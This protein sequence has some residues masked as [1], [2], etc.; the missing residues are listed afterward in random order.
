MSP[1]SRAGL[2]RLEM[3][4]VSSVLA[5][6][7]VLAVHWILTARE[8]ARQTQCRNHLRQIGL[9]LHNYHDSMST[10]PPGFISDPTDGPLT[11]WNG[12]GW[13]AS[14][15]P[16]I[17]ASPLYNQLNFSVPIWHNDNRRTLLQRNALFYNCYLCVSSKTVGETLTLKGELTEAVTFGRSH[18]V[19]N[20]GQ[21]PPWSAVEPSKDW[22]DVATGVLY[23]NSKV[24]IKDIEGGTSNTVLVGED[25][26]GANHTWVGVLPHTRNCLPN[27]V[28][29]QREP[30]CDGPAT[31]VLFTS[32][33][34]DSGGIFPPTR[35]SIRVNQLAS[36][37]P[38]AGHVVMADG[39]VRRVAAGMD[40]QLWSWL[41]DRRLKE[42]RDDWDASP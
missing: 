8:N 21:V 19:G 15:L 34:V 29:R 27:T 20:A 38:E 42:L 24:A 33:S 10:F 14:T 25:S 22:S 7:A 30:D 9:A 31:F 1:K 11:N 16:Y 3:V 40:S 6:G 4:V 39:A 18:Y 32:G 13:Q 36:A 37:H 17:D 2:T 35:E 5:L 26:N 23:R 12:F 28:Q 41:C